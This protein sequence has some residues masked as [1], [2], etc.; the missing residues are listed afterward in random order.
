MK[1]I[2]EKDFLLEDLEES[3]HKK[4]A[5]MILWLREW[6][7]YNW[8][9]T[10]LISTIIVSE[11]YAIILSVSPNFLVSL[12][13][14][15]GVSSIIIS[16]LLTGLLLL[17]IGLATGALFYSAHL[18]YNSMTTVEQSYQP[19]I[20]VWSK[21]TKIYSH[22]LEN[23][24]DDDNFLKI[25]QALK[26]FPPA[27]PLHEFLSRE[28]NVESV[29]KILV[30][31]KK[32][33]AAE[34]ADASIKT[35]A[36][37]LLSEY[38][39]EEN[40]KDHINRIWALWEILQHHEEPQ[41]D[42]IIKIIKNSSLIAPYFEQVQAFSSQPEVIHMV[43]DKPELLPYLNAV[44][45]TFK[46]DSS[47]VRAANI[48]SLYQLFQT[49]SP[50]HLSK[51]SPEQKPLEIHPEI[52]EMVK[53]LHAKHPDSFVCIWDKLIHHTHLSWAESLVLK[54][55]D[56]PY[57]ELIQDPL[58]FM[59]VLSIFGEIHLS[60]DAEIEA[61]NT[62]LAILSQDDSYDKIIEILHRL[63]SIHFFHI[64][65]I[66][67]MLLKADLSSNLVLLNVYLEKILDESQDEAQLTKDLEKLLINNEALHAQLNELAKKQMTTE[68]NLV[69][70]VKNYLYPE[71]IQALEQGQK[72]AKPFNP[73]RKL[74]KILH[75]LPEQNQAKAP[76]AVAVARLDSTPM[77]PMLVQTHEEAKVTEQ[78]TAR[79]D[80]KNA[81][82]IWKKHHES[83]IF[84]NTTTQR[85]I[86]E[87]TSVSSP[88]I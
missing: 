77:T 22:I 33:W 67:Q 20:E 45:K 16:S 38:V 14:S 31:L 11:I 28:E 61:F 65:F 63:N 50:I 34:T 69:L 42:L 47:T 10:S 86:D 53:S 6:N 9:M 44:N 68:E 25:T 87:E 21:N 55:K 26:D 4:N 12:W 88:G 23:L 78:E 24:L 27:R 17:S 1:T 59:R 15:L 85:T 48:K 81:Y 32:I 66:E 3:T 52:L 60:S 7:T 37:T 64:H 62:R 51:E 84:S 49:E 70:V 72:P 36:L 83:S 29:R 54:L 56:S 8:L 79:E 30:L 2:V 71:L 18:A 73:I 40:A 46:A 13:L 19:L 76:S 75:M 57:P 74:R 5:W 41:L 39:Q 82:R 35:L 58:Q 80:V 43:V